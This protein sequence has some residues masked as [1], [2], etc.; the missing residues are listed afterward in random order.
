MCMV[1]KQVS[2]RVL[3]AIINIKGVGFIVDILVMTGF[4]LD[5]TV[6]AWQK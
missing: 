2:I 4:S 3:I 1:L 6:G 5:Y